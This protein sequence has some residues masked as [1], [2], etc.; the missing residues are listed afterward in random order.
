MSVNEVPGWLV[1]IP[2]RAM[3]VPVAL[4]PGLVPH[5]D[6]LIVVPELAVGLLVGLLLAELLLP[7]EH[8][9][10]AT[11]PTTVSATVALKPDAHPY[12]RTCPHLLVVKA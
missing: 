4:T 3:G 2:P 9:A 1:T 10:S 5:C 11:I 6:V 7:L 12:I 8:P